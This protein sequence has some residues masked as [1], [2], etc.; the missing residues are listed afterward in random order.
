MSDPTTLEPVETLPPVAVSTSPSL[1]GV[2][3]DYSAAQPKFRL[4]VRVRATV[5]VCLRFSSSVSEDPEATVDDVE[6]GANQHE[7][8]DVLRGSKISAIRAASANADGILK[9]T[10]C[11]RAI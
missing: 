2:I 5:D 1:S 3:G 6:L 10:I 7:Y 11:K 9:I 8:F 4:I